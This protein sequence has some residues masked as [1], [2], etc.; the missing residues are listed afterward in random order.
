VGLGVAVL[1]TVG[2]WL[3]VAVG[4]TSVGVRVSVGV[5]VVVFVGCFS[6]GTMDWLQA[7]K[8]IKIM[9]KI[10]LV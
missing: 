2:V 4:G 10:N 9:K 3:G 1:V 7:D 8:K 5:V 6:V